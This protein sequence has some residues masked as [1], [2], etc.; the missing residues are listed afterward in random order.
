MRLRRDKVAMAGGVV[1]VFLILVAI[2]GP[3]LVQNPDIY[4]SNLID[5]MYSGPTGRS[6]GSVS[7][8]RSASSR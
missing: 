8:T 6:A 5:P 1:V 7:R 2:V 3:Y 4:H